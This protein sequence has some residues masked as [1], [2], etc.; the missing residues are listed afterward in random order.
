M[1]ADGHYWHCSF[2]EGMDIANGI[3][4]KTVTN[5]MSEVWN[6]EKT[7]QWRTRLLE[8]NRECPLYKEIHINPSEAKGSFPEKM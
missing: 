4:M 8:L 3:D 5:F 2:G 7:N 6:S 1:D